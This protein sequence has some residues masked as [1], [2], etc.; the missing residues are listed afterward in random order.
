MPPAFNLS[1]DQTLKFNPI[2]PNSSSLTCWHSISLL[3]CSKLQCA[4]HE[5]PHLSVVQV[6]KEQ[7]NY[8]SFPTSPQCVSLSALRREMRFCQNHN[9]ASSV[10]FLLFCLRRAPCRRTANPNQQNDRS[11]L[12][13]TRLP[14]LSPR[15]I[16]VSLQQRGETLATSDEDVNPSTPQNQIATE[17]VLASL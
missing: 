1:Q 9:L 12:Q 8:F 2:W 15:R 7:L 14:P 13:P 6:F 4:F 10:L 5:R 3:P 11:K 16:A 17:R